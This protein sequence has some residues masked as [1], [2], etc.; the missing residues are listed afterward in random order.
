MTISLDTQGL[1]ISSE[2][3]ILCKIL[4]LVYSYKVSKMVIKYILYYQWNAV[5][6]LQY[7]LYSQTF[8]L[9]LKNSYIF[10]W[11]I[12]KVLDKLE[13]RILT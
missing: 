8:S 7:N 6:S 13:S 5:V 4:F 1:H 10:L 9:S 12:L 11:Y 3:Q 2:Q